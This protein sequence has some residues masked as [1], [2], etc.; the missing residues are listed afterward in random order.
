MKKRICP[1]CMRGYI[2]GGVC[3]SCKKPVTKKDV[4]DNTLPLWYPLHNRYQIGRVIGRGGFGVTYL[5]WDMK[6]NRRICIKELNPATV[7]DRGT[8]SGY[9]VVKEGQESYWNYIKDRFYKEAETIRKLQFNPE[10]LRIYSCFND[11]GTIYYSMEYLEGQDL[12]RLS[13]RKGKFSWDEMKGYINT[14]LN[15]LQFLHGLGLIHRDISPDNI[16]VVVDRRIKLLDFG[17]VRTTAK[18]HFTEIFKGSFAPPEMWIGKDQGSWTDTFAVCATIYYL[19]NGRKAPK[20]SYDRQFQIYSGKPDPLVPLAQYQPDAPA[21]VIQAIE[22]GMSLDRDKRYQ[23]IQELRKD[24]FPELN[25]PTSNEN[26]TKVTY[27]LLVCTRG[28]YA[29]KKYRLPLNK[30]IKLGRGPGD[31]KIS[32]PQD[33]KASVGISHNHC[34]FY[35]DGQG[36]HYV[37][38][39]GSSYGTYIGGKQLRPGQWYRVFA[40]QPI[41]I[42]G[43]EYQFYN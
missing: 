9:I 31:N 22:K 43:E 16:F 14:L 4:S 27:S 17:S 15:Q 28:L 7:V 10:I 35:V 30:V 32:Y 37:Q 36:Y 6:E 5:A 39:V 20:R 23:S 26:A 2:S 18:E 33:P 8:G 13:Q 42:G 3:T 19:L 29:G 40:R 24:L 11:L 25:V 12:E 21:Y 34:A 1:N 41:M 38:D